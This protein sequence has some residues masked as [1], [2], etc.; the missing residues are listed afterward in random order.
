VVN[1]SATIAAALDG[2]WLDR[3]VA[4]PVVVHFS[5]R[6]DDGRWVVELRSWPDAAGPETTAAA[7]D[8]IDLPDDA[9]ATLLEPRSRGRLPG[10]RL[11]TAEIAA[12]VD[13]AS[14][15]SGHGRPITYPYIGTRWP[16][17]HYQTV[18]ATEPG[19]AEMPS[20][21]R[22]FTTELVT[23]LVSAG[24]RVAPIC[25]HTGVSSLEAGE[26]PD[27]ERFDVPETTARLV[28]WTRQQGGRVIAVGTTVTRALESALDS[29]GAVAA[30]GGWTDLVLGPEHPARVVDGL[31]TGLHAP[32]ASH[33]LL[34]EAV[35]G[36]DLVQQ[37]YDAALDHRYR[38]HEFGDACLLLPERSR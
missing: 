15:L 10:T 38:W 7:G 5:A 29:K 24:V 12:G 14:Y 33:L 28:E 37:V 27:A 6:L 16:L 34:L 4:R 13:V 30:A 36:A 18:F 21:G 8:R 23:R 22:P 11:W 31:V 17:D 3:G 1:T 20:A 32:D 26:P 19:S 2:A 25:L 9:S 35:A